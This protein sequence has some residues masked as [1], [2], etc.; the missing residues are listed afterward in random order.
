MR[1]GVSIC[2]EFNVCCISNHDYYS[3]GTA[4]HFKYI[5]F[6]NVTE[7]L[8]GTGV[9]VSIMTRLRTGRPRFDSYWG[10]RDFSLHQNILIGS[11]VKPASF[12]VSIG[13]FLSLG[14]KRLGVKLTI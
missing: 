10:G 1:T 3:T 13:G 5:R 9:A 6:G 8:K 2:E 14:I 4:S 7:N 12:V 11:G